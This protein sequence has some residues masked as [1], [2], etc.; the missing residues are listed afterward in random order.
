MY[1]TVRRY[2]GFGLLGVML[3]TAVAVPVVAAPQ[4]GKKGAKK[5]GKGGK[6]APKKGGKKASK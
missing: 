2:L 4:T 5:G 1:Q 6:G 3:A